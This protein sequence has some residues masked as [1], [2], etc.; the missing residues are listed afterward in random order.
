MSLT[1]RES[2]V[3]QHVAAGMSNDEIAAALELSRNTVRNRL[4]GVFKKL[5]N[6][7]NRVKAVNV[8]RSRGLL[9]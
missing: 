8:A 6:V 3:L 5:G 7:D 1:R 2:E 9:Q 4:A